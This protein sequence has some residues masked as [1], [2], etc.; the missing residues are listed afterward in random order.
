MGILAITIAKSSVWMNPK[1]LFTPSKSVSESE[2]DQRI[3]KTDPK[4]Y[5]ENEN[6]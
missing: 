4:T 6:S 5:H 3:S 2:K 1:G